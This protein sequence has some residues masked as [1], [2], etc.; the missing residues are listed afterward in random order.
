MTTSDRPPTPAVRPGLVVRDVAFAIAGAVAVAVVTAHIEVGAGDPSLDAG[1]YACI[2]VAFLALSL[3][4]FA[5]FAVLAVVVTALAIYLARDYPGGPVYVSLFAA[6]YVVALQRPT[7]VALAAGV[8]SAGVLVLVGEIADTGPGLVHLIFVGWAAA[9]VFLGQAVRNRREY[10]RALEDRAEQLERSRDEEARR[11]V[12]EERLRIAQDLHDSVAH[13]M[14]TINVQA[15]VAAHLLDRHPDRAAEALRAV[16]EASGEVL[17]EL[18]AL[19]GVLRV[20]TDGRDVR[21]PTPGAGDVG[22]LVEA[23]RLAGVG[24]ELHDQ[25][26]LGHVRQPVGVALYRI[27]QEALTNVARHAGQGATA[28]VSIEGQPGDALR[29]SVVDDG[30]GAPPAAARAGVGVGVVGMRERA[31]STGGELEA[32]PSPGGGYAV[33]A[34]WSDP[35]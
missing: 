23:S 15:G 17:D 21:H 31:E 25:A 30:Q 13:S 35:W 34:T 5:P 28:V 18:A 3:W 10:V 16:K 1:A 6:L 33:R 27:V 19:V 12:A 2:G 7:R 9:S 11:R 24:V 8:V 29:L 22:R 26:D 4:R 14:A 32:G 20:D